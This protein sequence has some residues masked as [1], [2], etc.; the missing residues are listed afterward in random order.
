MKNIIKISL[1]L[2][3]VASYFFFSCEKED[4]TYQGPPVVEFPIPLDKY[5]EKVTDTT[6]HKIKVQ[7]VAPHQSS[8]VTMNFKVIEE[9]IIA[10]DTF[11]TTAVEGTHYTLPSMS[12]TIPANSSFGYIDINLL[13][14]DNKNQDLCLELTNGSVAASPNYKRYVIRIKNKN[15]NK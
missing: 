3:L 8:A 5:P 6:A 15:P 7:L 12:V 1:A 11:R 9:F 2:L 13:P 4:L 14:T 10:T